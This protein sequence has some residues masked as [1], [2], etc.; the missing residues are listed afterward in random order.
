MPKV[1]V[2]VEVSVPVFSTVT[3]TV[4]VDDPT[5]DN[6]IL[7]AIKAKADDDDVI[8]D[9]NHYMDDVEDDY[10]REGIKHGLL[11][12]GYHSHRPNCWDGEIRERNVVE[13]AA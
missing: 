12:P 13:A 5:D 3:A 9:F 6:A 11:D 2:K 4:D 7:E 8:I 10:V 1:Q